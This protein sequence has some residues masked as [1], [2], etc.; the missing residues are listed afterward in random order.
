MTA[1]ANFTDIAVLDEAGFDVDI[2]T[3]QTLH[4]VVVTNTDATDVVYLKVFTAAVVDYANDAP[5]FAIDIPPGAWSLGVG[6]LCPRIRMQ[7]SSVRG[8]G[9]TAPAADL[10][11]LVIRG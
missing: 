8:A 9:N 7:A 11:V 5:A 6:I 2:T 10:S 1:P 3:P 4:R